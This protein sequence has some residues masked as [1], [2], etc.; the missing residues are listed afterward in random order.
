MVEDEEE[1]E[2]V[3]SVGRKRGGGENKGEDRKQKVKRT[4]RIEKEQK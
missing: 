4:R 3:E 1:V 2:E